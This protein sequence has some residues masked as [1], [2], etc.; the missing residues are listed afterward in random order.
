MCFYFLAYDIMSRSDVLYEVSSFPRADRAAAEYAVKVNNFFFH[1]GH[2]A[3]A[4]IICIRELVTAA[5][6]RGG[7]ATTLILTVG[8]CQCHVADS[9]S[10]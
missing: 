2:N 5:V 9:L 4:Y 1:R 10:P 6:E 3:N 7:L 8:N